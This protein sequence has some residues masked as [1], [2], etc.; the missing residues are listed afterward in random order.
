MVVY[1]CNSLTK[2][3]ARGCDILKIMSMFELA[4]Q[5]IVNN[6]D[7]VVQKITR[8]YQINSKIFTSKNWDLNFIQIKQN[9]WTMPRICIP[10]LVTRHLA[11]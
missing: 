10:K 5:I 7:H 9:N 6:L 8:S 2:S 1:Y 11:Q 3:F 4:A